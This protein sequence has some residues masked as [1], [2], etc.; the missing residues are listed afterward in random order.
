MGDPVNG[1]TVSNTFKGITAKDNNVDGFHVTGNDVA[2]DDGRTFE[3]NTSIRNTGWGLFVDAVLSN[4]FA[5]NN[6]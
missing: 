3:N 4:T 2:N 5:N 1:A 6:C